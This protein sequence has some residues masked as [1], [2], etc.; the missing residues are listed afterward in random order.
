M[1]KTISQNGCTDDGYGTLSEA[2]F[3]SSQA[4]ANF[5][6]RRKTQS[7][8]MGGVAMSHGAQTYSTRANDDG[9]EGPTC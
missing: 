3:H 2:G 6:N 4:C 8:L 1:R 5:K 9:G 7:F